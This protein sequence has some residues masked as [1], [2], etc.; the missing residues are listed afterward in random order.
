MNVEERFDPEVEKIEN[1]II[2]TLLNYTV[3]S[4]RGEIT[5]KILFYFITRKDLTQSKL[6][7]LTGFSAGK[8]SQELNNLMEFNL[9][10]ISK[11]SKP[12]IYSMESVIVEMFS[13]AITLLKTNIRWETKFLEMKGEL[14]ENRGELQKLNGYDEV[15]EFI[16][17]N[18]ARFSGFKVVIKLWE[19]LKK[20]YE[21][22]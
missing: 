19:D 9:I 21:N 1:E 22:E 6:Q 3:F 20:K 11:K 5:S 15:K 13:R 2:N 16:E 10:K 14:E 18:L 17:V 4:I 12:W 8:I 7:Q